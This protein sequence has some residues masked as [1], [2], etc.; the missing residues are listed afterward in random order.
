MRSRDSLQLAEAAPGGLLDRAPALEASLIASEIKIFLRSFKENLEKSKKLK[1]AL[2][3]MARFVV[4]KKDLK[5]IINTSKISIDPYYYNHITFCQSLFTVCRPRLG[6]ECPG[7]V[8]AVF[9]YVN[10]TL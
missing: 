1:V 6:V 4:I 2:K 10:L 9:I 5:M 8:G 3:E 7:E